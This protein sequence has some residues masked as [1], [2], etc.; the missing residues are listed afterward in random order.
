MPA[1]NSSLDSLSFLSDSLR[2]MLH[3]RL[4]EIAGVALVAGALLLTAALASWSVQD[5]SLSH[6][7]VNP[8]RTSRF[9]REIETS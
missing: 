9:T 1:I 3:R 5:P 8:V 4:R 6:A 2:E 7:T